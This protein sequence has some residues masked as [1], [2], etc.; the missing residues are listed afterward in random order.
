MA[1]EGTKHFSKAII[2]LL[3]GLLV[4]SQLCWMRR[5]WIILYCG[6]RRGILT[7][8]GLSA[9]CR[10]HAQQDASN[11][12]HQDTL[13]CLDNLFNT[14]AQICRSCSQHT[15][16]V[17]M[18]CLR[19]NECTCDLITFSPEKNFCFIDEDSMNIWTT[20]T[21]TFILNFDSH[22]G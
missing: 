2:N 19:N 6:E 9:S 12:S 14:I 22:P 11:I 1:E 10:L 17:I 13:F 5:R 8:V 3:D 18:G 4:Y 21:E 16:T 7:Q 15:N 20:I